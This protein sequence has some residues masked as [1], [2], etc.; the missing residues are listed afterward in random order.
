MLVTRDADY[1]VMLNLVPGKSSAA[2]V[3][4]G[5]ELANHFVPTPT[6]MPRSVHKMN[7]HVSKLEASTPTLHTFDDT[8]ANVVTK[9]NDPLDLKSGGIVQLPPLRLCSFAS[10]QQNHH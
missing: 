9:G 4:F 1:C 7:P 6:A 3:S 2:T 8:G 10:R 5:F